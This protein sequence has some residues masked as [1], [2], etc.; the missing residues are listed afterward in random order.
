MEHA[1]N[2]HMIPPAGWHAASCGTSKTRRLRVGCRLLEEW[3][4]SEDFD[5]QEGLVP[6]NSFE[7]YV[8]CTQVTRW[9]DVRPRCDAVPFVE[10]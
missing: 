5:Q 1:L 8:E 10:R 4:G 2:L 9:T 7:F 3:Y 6:K